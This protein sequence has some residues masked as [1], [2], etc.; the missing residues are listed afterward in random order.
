MRPFHHFGYVSGMDRAHAEGV[1]GGAAAPWRG[2]AEV[3]DGE[4][5]AGA[6]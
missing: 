3:C 1:S 6:P 2:S 5:R 4:G